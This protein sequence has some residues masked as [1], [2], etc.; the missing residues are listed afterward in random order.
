MNKTTEAL[1]LAEEALSEM[2]QLM[3]D[4]RLGDYKPDTFTNQPAEEALAAIR[5]ALAEEPLLEPEGR[6]KECM[7][8]NGHL[9]CCSNAEPVK[10][11]PV[12]EYALSAARQLLD[13][14]D[15]SDG[16]QYGTLSTG[17]VRDAM[18]QILPA[19]IRAA[20]AERQWVDLTCE[21]VTALIR[22]GAAGGSLQGFA[23][24]VQTAFK[25]RNK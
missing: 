3:D 16:C 23:S 17:V 24:W 15:E 7:A 12:A 25:E 1:K 8:Y 2:M 5:E 9:D 21:E 6:C 22:E 11:E 13:Y 19:L 18:E 4:I 10:Q 20:P 14:A